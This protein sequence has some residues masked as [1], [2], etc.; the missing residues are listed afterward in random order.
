MLLLMMV[1]QNQQIAIGM[2][3]GGPVLHCANT[4]PLKGC[5][6]A[7]TGQP[8]PDLSRHDF[9]VIVVSRTRFGPVELPVF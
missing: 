5:R 4:S 9:N 3:P 7:F 8:V 1:I 6:Y 2:R